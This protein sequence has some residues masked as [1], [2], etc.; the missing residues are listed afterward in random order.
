MRKV[1][2]AYDGDFVF[3]GG[4]ALNYQK[5]TFKDVL[6]VICLRIDVYEC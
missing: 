5:Q 4:N 6:K 2:W 3:W 1:K